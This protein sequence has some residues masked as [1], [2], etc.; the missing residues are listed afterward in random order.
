MHLVIEQSIIVLHTP[1]QKLIIEDTY[2]YLFSFST[3]RV[4]KRNF[5]ELKPLG[6]LDP[7][8]LPLFTL[9]CPEKELPELYPQIPLYLSAAFTSLLLRDP[10]FSDSKVN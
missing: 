3:F 4:V 9:L 1:I 8:F 6:V 10:T 7:L 2:N 5:K